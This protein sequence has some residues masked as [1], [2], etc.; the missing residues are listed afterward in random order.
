MPTRTQIINQLLELI[1]KITVSSLDG[2]INNQQVIESNM[3]PPSGLLIDFLLQHR[4]ELTEWKSEANAIEQV[5]NRLVSDPASVLRTHV[6]KRLQQKNQFL[7]LDPEYLAI[8]KEIYRDLLQ[9]LSNALQETTDGKQLAEDWNQILA[10]YQQHLTLFLQSITR[11]ASP[12]EVSALDQEVVCSEYS[13]ELQLKLLGIDPS[14]LLEPILDL[15]C[16]EHAV[17]VAHLRQLGKEAFGID[18]IAATNPYVATRDWFEGQ[19]PPQTWGTIISH[20]GFS[21]HFLHYHL[22]IGEQAARYAQKYMEI[23]H[24]LLPDGLFVYAP[25]LPFIERL[26]PSNEYRI[27][28]IPIPGSDIAN[29]LEHRLRALLGDSPFYTCQIQRIK[30]P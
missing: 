15:G 20:Q 21:T 24:A 2:I 6:L 29:I 3:P 28:R 26:L 1:S 27:T 18:R 5:D 9:K 13:T 7:D 17:L 4:A 19:L 11:V 30:V 8:L 16:G 10:D 25:G 23:L 12:S 22:R 14:T